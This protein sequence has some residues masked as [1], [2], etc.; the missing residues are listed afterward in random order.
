M[1]AK[2]VNRQKEC[3]L[4]DPDCKEDCARC[5]WNPD[6]AERR[7]IEL[8]KNRLTTGEDGLQRLIIK[9]EA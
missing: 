2:K 6:E 7:A 3:L 4:Q 1:E 9:R 8:A 5:G